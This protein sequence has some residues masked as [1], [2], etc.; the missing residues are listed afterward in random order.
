MLMLVQRPQEEGPG[1]TVTVTGVTGV[2]HVAAYRPSSDGH[3]TLCFVEKFQGNMILNVQMCQ[4]HLVCIYYYFIQSFTV[5]KNLT[6]RIVVI[7]GAF[8]SC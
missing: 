2:T 8:V 7:S 1:V 3:F 5:N 4:Y 6:K